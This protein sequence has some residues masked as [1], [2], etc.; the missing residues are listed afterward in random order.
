[1]SSGEVFEVFVDEHGVCVVRGE[2]DEATGMRLE[3]RLQQHPEV[4]CVDLGEVSFV[5]SAGL[6]CLLLLRQRLI[7]RGDSLVV[8]R[9]SGAV[10]RLLRLAGVSN[11]FM[12]PV[13]DEGSSAAS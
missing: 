2:L 8:R 12:T 1:V 5:D 6:R 13:N 7:D 11:L 10:R 3:A 4:T 9:S